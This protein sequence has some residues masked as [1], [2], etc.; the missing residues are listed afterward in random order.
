ME[1]GFDSKLRQ[2]IDMLVLARNDSASFEHVSYANLVALN[3]SFLMCQTKA[4][5]V[6]KIQIAD[7]NGNK[8]VD[9]MKYDP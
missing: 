7:F 5:N 8:S 6:F 9:N 1:S 3:S 4:R 2:H